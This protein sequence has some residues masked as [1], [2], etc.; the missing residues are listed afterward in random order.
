MNGDSE[1]SRSGGQQNILGKGTAQGQVR[2][3]LV[4]LESGFYMRRIAASEEVDGAL[5]K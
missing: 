3:I 1:I 5:A 2:Y 4:W